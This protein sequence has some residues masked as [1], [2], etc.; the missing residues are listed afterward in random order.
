M[1][2][3]IERKEI[4]SSLKMK[5]CQECKTQFRY[6]K[7]KV[8]CSSYCRFKNWARLHPRGKSINILKEG[9]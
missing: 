6:R 2:N 3:I 5:I 4:I 7:N 8:F 9:I 1:S